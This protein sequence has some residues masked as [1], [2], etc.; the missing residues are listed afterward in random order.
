MEGVGKE[1]GKVRA[2]KAEGSLSL[3]GVADVTLTSGGPKL[4]KEDDVI[5]GECR[6]LSGAEDS[7]EVR[8]I[9][10]KLMDGNESGVLEH[11]FQL[12]C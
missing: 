6:Y 2:R 1:E 5:R 4:S 12:C 9:L 11:G 8:E 7:R 3:D 10:G